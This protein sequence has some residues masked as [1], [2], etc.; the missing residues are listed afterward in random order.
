MVPV[1]HC[2]CFHHRPK[3]RVDYAIKPVMYREK[4]KSKCKTQPETMTMA[5]LVSLCAAPQLAC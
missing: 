2:L 4:N 5:R 1:A 3:T